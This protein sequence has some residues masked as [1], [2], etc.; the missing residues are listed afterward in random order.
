MTMTRRCTETLRSSCVV[1]ATAVPCVN[2]ARVYTQPVEERVC[3]IACEGDVVVLEAPTFVFRLDTADGLRAI[4]W[5]N[6]QTGRQLQLGNGPEVEFDI[7]LPD[8]SPVTPKLRVTKK[9][10]AASGAAGRRGVRTCCRKT[11]RRR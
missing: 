4:A 8:K 7:G 11:V 5:T 3:R 1:A 10:A 2:W 6:R 9:P